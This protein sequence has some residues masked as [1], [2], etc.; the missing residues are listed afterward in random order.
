MYKGSQAFR[1]P[2]SGNGTRTFVDGVEVAEVR[3]L[4]LHSGHHPKLSMN[5]VPTDAGQARLYDICLNDKEQHP[6]RFDMEFALPDGCG[7]KLAFYRCAVA[8]YYLA[9]APNDVATLNMN[10]TYAKAD[11][12]VEPYRNTEDGP[13][14]DVIRKET[15][16]GR[17]D[18]W[19]NMLEILNGDLM[20]GLSGSIY[21]FRE[22]QRKELLKEE[23]IRMV[24]RRVC[25]EVK[26]KEQ[27]YPQTTAPVGGG[28]V[29]AMFPPTQNPADDTPWW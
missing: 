10:F 19:D 6:R 12:V 21:E 5:F 22:W 1:S 13:E 29:E 14:V 25:A 4:D 17:A 16:N 26:A 15:Q 27:P 28:F 7:T 18:H 3:F 2:F 20:R 9:L 11:I 23:N 24:I 8:E